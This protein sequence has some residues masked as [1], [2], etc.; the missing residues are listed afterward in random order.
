MGDTQG[1]V[2][3]EILIRSASGPFRCWGLLNESDG[4]LLAYTT[5]MFLMGHAIASNR[6]A[7]KALL[8]GKTGAGV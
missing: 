1:C 5:G 6:D 8:I 2:V 7:F 4:S 3:T